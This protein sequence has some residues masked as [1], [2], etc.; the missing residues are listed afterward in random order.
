MHIQTMKGGNMQQLT[1]L[2]TVLDR[3]DQL[4]Q[5][6]HDKLISV[7]DV[8]FDDFETVRVAGEPHKMRRMDSRGFLIG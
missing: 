3:V 2:G 4:S 1:T 6:C 7:A 5:N 8:S